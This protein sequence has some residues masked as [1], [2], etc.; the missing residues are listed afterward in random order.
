MT[1]WSVYFYLDDFDEIR[2]FEVQAPSE[3]EA[4]ALAEQTWPYETELAGAAIVYPVTS[5]GGPLSRRATQR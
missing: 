3:A 1:R 5:V 2:E 4:V